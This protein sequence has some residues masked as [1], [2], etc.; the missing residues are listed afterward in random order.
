M[1]ESKVFCDTALLEPQ[2]RSPRLPACHWQRQALAVT[3]RPHRHCLSLCV[4]SDAGRQ[5][6]LTLRKFQRLAPDPPASHWQSW[7]RTSPLTEWW[8]LTSRHVQ[9][10]Q[11]HEAT[12]SWTQGSCPG[13]EFMPTSGRQPA[14]RTPL[15]AHE[16][17]DD[18]QHSTKTHPPTDTD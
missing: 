10:S 5:G 11:T 16:G 4:L 8:P 13:P 7:A 15:P 6:P 1:K 2:A 18:T 3:K 12:A 9:G 17:E 14:S